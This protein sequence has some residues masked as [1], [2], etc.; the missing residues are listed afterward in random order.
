VIGSKAVYI[1]NDDE[2]S[3]LLLLQLLR[4]LFIFTLNRFFRFDLVCHYFSQSLS[5]RPTEAPSKEVSDGPYGR[6]PIVFSVTIELIVEL[7]WKPP[8]PNQHKGVGKRPGS[9]V[10]RRR[11]TKG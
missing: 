1:I 10:L 8:S 2:E 11:T 4:E 5:E 9:K 6:G 3:F 7:R